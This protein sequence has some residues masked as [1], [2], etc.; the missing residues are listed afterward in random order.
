MAENP[1]HTK[2]T[3]RVNQ[4]DFLTLQQAA[5]KN[6]KNKSVQPAFHPRSYNG[7]VRRI[8]ERECHKIRMFASDMVDE[9]GVSYDPNTSA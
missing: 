2:T 5:H 7:I 3:I 8:L 6:D 4:A 1:K 9:G